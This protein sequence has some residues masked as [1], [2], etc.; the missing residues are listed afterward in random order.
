MDVKIQNNNLIVRAEPVGY[1]SR[2]NLKGDGLTKS[3]AGLKGEVLVGNG[4]FN[5]GD[6][7]EFQRNMGIEIRPNIYV[8]K[9]DS[10]FLTGDLDTFL[11]KL[12]PKKPIEDLIKKSKDEE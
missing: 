6:K 7:I 9:T 5:V 8:I 3:G 1:V 11:E 2:N 12:E 4:N 10:V